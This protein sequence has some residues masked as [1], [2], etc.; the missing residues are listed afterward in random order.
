MS[1]LVGAALKLTRPL[2]FICNRVTCPYFKFP[3][4]SYIWEVGV[5]TTMFHQ[6]TYSISGVCAICG[7]ETSHLIE[8][9]RLEN[10]IDNNPD[11]KQ[12]QI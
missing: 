12:W 3:E 1:R 8:R 6:E 4:G 10:L 5:N 2:P 7:R 11:W 9:K